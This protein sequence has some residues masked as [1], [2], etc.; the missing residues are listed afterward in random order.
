MLCLLY[1]QSLFALAPTNRRFAEKNDLVGTLLSSNQCSFLN[2][3][4]NGNIPKIDQDRN[5]KKFCD[6]AEFN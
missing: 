5:S 4:V 6:M 1:C 3:V 2:A